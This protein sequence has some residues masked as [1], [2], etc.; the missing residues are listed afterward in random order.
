MTA[1]V[2][3]GTGLVGGCLLH[4]LVKSKRYDRIVA[5]VRQLPAVS[6]LPSAVEAVAV[7]FD[8]LGRLSPFPVDD[9]FS[10]LGTTIG[11]AG[12]K[13]AFRRIDHGYPFAFGQW[14]R[15]V[16]AR[17]LLL[18]SS[19]AADPASPNFYLRVKAEL[20]EG[21][22]TLGYASLHIFRPGMLFGDRKE[23]R[24]AERI[25]I[26]VAKAVGWALI[27]S[28]R[29]YRGIEAAR[30]ARAMSRCAAEGIPGKHIYHFDEI[31]RLA[32]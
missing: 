16:G 23:S 14:G 10:C 31:V 32:A 29:K 25:G 7:D 15:A 12:S 2:A 13:E 22:G 19:V 11:K 3:G 1:L 24:P 26:G 6:V 17:Q 9:V 20:E 28:L 21:L 5:V 18:V 8:N 4:E 30:V 27:G